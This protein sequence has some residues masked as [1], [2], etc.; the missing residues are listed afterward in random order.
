M[1]LVELQKENERLRK[2]LASARIWMGKEVKSQMWK[3]WELWKSQQDEDLENV[4]EV[5][6]QKISDFFW[7]I[8]LLN[9][10]TDVIENI[11]Y[12]EVNYHNLRENPNFDGLGVI[13]S[14]HKSLDS[15]IESFIT[16]WFRKFAHKQW[17]TIL[18]KNEPLEKSLNSVVNKWYILSTGRLYHLIT[19]I[20]E[21]GEL[22]DYWK[23]FKNYLEKY[24]NLSEI[25]FSQE[26]IECFSDLMESETL[27]KKRH[28]GKI[29]FIETRKARQ[30]LIWDLE[31]TN[32]LIYKL[33]ETQKID[34]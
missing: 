33:I 18:R 22:Y 16:K 34:Y 19:L 26:F 15:L 20:K 1:N 32:S 2:I 7:E 12:A 11:I 31:N 6:T 10:P 27:G 5:I 21:D 3:L 29:S 25:L 13:S 9:I 24:V 28:I 23:C 30:L 8:M 4:E 17:Q 14:Y